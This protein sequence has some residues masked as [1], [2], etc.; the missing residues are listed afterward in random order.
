[1]SHPNPFFMTHDLRLWVWVSI[2]VAETPICDGAGLLQN[3]AAQPEFI[4]PGPAP[5]AFTE[6]RRCGGMCLA[7]TETPHAAFR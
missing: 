2:F 5:I 3:D 1:V 4:F 6:S 7:P